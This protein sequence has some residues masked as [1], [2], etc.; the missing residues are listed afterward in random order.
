MEERTRPQKTTRG[1][2]PSTSLRWQAPL[3]HCSCFHGDTRASRIPRVRLLLLQCRHCSK[4]T[5]A[6][7][8]R[9]GGPR[10]GGIS[11]LACGWLCTEASAALASNPFPSPTT[12]AL[13]L[14]TTQLWLQRPWSPRFGIEGTGTSRPCRD[15]SCAL[16]RAQ[17]RGRLVFRGTCCGAVQTKAGLCA[18]PGFRAFRA[19]RRG[20]P[21]LWE[22][23]EGALCEPC[24]SSCASAVENKP[25]H[26]AHLTASRLLRRDR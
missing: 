22:W 19:Q 6:G 2:H 14:T 26:R 9:C 13:A 21:T 5:L 16:V 4:Q 25:Q 10:M 3:K 18:S 7:T 8:V 24:A 15:S 17:L 11:K 1:T 23:S 20:S 12:T